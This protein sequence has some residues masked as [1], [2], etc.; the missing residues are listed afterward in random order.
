[1][2]T[3]PDQAAASAAP[4]PVDASDR[5]HLSHARTTLLQALRLSSRS[6]VPGSRRPRREHVGDLRPVR[7]RAGRHYG[8][9][10]RQSPSA[11]RT[12]WLALIASHRGPAATAPAAAPGTESPATT[13][14]RSDD[15]S[16]TRGDQGSTVSSWARSA[17]ARSG[18]PM[19]INAPYGAVCGYLRKRTSGVGRRQDLFHSDRGEHPRHERN[20]FRV[21][22][23]HHHGPNHCPNRLTW[24]RAAGQGKPE[25]LN[26]LT[27][28]AR[29]SAQ[30][31]CAAATALGRIHPGIREAHVRSAALAHKPSGRLPPFPRAQERPDSSRRRS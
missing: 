4:G 29:V 16:T 14:S 22:V 8:V 10:G 12:T 25:V 6:C 21:V 26:L 9:R 24:G 2:I 11:I 7:L 13:K 5:C 17:S 30:H 3:V 31:R 27:G 15:V 18:R 28:R 1:L 23:D 20:K 19:S